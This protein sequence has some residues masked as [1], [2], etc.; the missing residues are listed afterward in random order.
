VLE[1]HRRAMEQLMTRYA[2][3]LQRIN[4]KITT[5]RTALETRA[6]EDNTS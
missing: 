4:D 6:K 2:E 5:Y 1:R 3:H